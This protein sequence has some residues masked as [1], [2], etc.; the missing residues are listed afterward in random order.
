[1]NQSAL[2]PITLC[3][4]PQLLTSAVAVITVAIAMAWSAPAQAMTVIEALETVC[5]QAPDV[6]GDAVL[7]KKIS[8]ACFN[9]GN[10]MNCALAILDVAGGGQ[11]EK[12]RTYVDAIVSCVNELKKVQPIQGIC[13]NILS[14]A[15]V[16][17]DKLNDAEAVVNQCKDIKDVDDA[18]VCAD[19]I[20]GSPIVKEQ[21]LSIPSWVGSLFDVYMA[22]RDKDYWQ[23]VYKVGAT[24]AC[25]V[26]NYFTGVDV[27]G[28][29][30]EIE[31][32]GGAVYAD[33]AA[34]IDFIGE[35]ASPS[36]KAEEQGQYFAEHWLPVVASTA[37]MVRAD[38]S[39]WTPIAKPLWDD[40]Y[41]YYSE[42]DMDAQNAQNLC[43]DM[44][45][46]ST[47]NDQYFS[48]RGFT[49]LVSRQMALQHLVELV[50]LRVP[51]INQQVLQGVN[52]MPEKNSKDPLLKL[53]NGY[54]KVIKYESDIHKLFGYT[55][56]DALK[57]SP[58]LAWEISSTGL[59][60]VAEIEKAGIPPNYLD[61]PAMYQL[62][63][64]ALAAAEIKTK[65]D[66]RVS[67]LIKSLNSEKAKKAKEYAKFEAS[68]EAGV[69]KASG[70]P[71]LVAAC[72][73]SS[74]LYQNKC[75]Q[76]VNARYAK[77]LKK[78]DDFVHA[79]PEVSGIDT[80]KAKAAQKQFDSLNY[81]CRLDIH[82]WVTEFTAVHRVWFEKVPK[83][84]QILSPEFNM[85][86][87]SMPDKLKPIL[88]PC[89]VDGKDPLI[90]QCP[91]GRPSAASNII[92][93][94][95]QVIGKGNVSDCAEAELAHANG[96]VS[97]CVVWHLKTGGWGGSP[98][99][100]VSANEV[101]LTVRPCPPTA[102]NCAPSLMQSPKVNSLNSLSNAPMPH[103]LPPSPCT[104]NA[105]SCSNPQLMAQVLT[106]L[107]CTSTG[108]RPSAEYLC[109]SPE[110]YAL[111]LD[112]Q[113]VDQ[114]LRSC[115]VSDPKHAKAIDATHMIH[116]VGCVP[117][118]GVSGEFSC[119]DAAAAFACEVIA[120]RRTAT[121]D[122]MIKR[123]H[124]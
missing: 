13:K 74:L 100:V 64:D 106:K 80:P 7:A 59:A 92:Q 3:R 53:G 115:R 85:N 26:G 55:S 60:A 52:E 46:G 107:G 44:R 2:F 104:P 96:V 29:L 78:G 97:P 93:Q 68:F 87:E 50:V 90:I 35:I 124:K 5:A 37:E 38:G 39:P 86:T 66:M 41:K 20:L 102:P 69:A 9:G 24:V 71:D 11:E 12:A 42:S 123:C 76:E 47:K 16:S 77:C 122:S 25:A 101:A 30:G 110:G 28:L 103:T 73:L 119:P 34:I 61:T 22:I 33:A 99:S 114:T 70:L 109:R 94:A 118:A 36:Y 4:M 89:V 108:G 21:D 81:T 31:K 10:E 58:A 15:G 116:Q 121:S 23:L 98:V 91:K 8:D 84:A 18:I 72:K 32:I 112:F 49:Q 45:D 54:P 6:C 67:E 82:E 40:C 14:S 83:V 56:A 57:K 1:M 62:A 19:L 65:L 48:G 117:I 120:T 111:C 51:A 17:V 79:H 88:S 113:R 63:S 75:E 27:C 105:T 95:E 43:D